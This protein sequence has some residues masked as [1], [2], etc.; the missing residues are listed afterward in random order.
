MIGTD[1]GHLQS[2]GLPRYL[3]PS[4]AAKHPTGLV[5]AGCLFESAVVMQCPGIVVECSQPIVL[6]HPK[7]VTT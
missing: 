2:A 3:P 4:G 6:L 1:F 7:H 5:A